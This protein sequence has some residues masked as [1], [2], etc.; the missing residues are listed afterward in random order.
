MDIILG[1]KKDNGR[2]KQ[3]YNQSMII[4]E[5]T[6]PS[7]RRNISDTLDDK[8]LSF[9]R[10]TAYRARSPPPIVSN[11]NNSY[12][13]VNMPSSNRMT[14]DPVSTLPPFPFHVPRAHKVP[15]QPKRIEWNYYEIPEGVEF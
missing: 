8:A 15:I 2:S 10:L 1:L 4:D 3:S 9:D 14:A 5:T 6:N 7:K 13:A 12:G 11:S